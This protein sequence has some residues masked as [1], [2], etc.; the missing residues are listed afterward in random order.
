[1]AETHHIVG[2]PRGEP[3]PAGR[4]GARIRVPLSGT[5]SAD[6]S[7]V[8]TAR[9]TAALTGHQAVGHLQLGGVIHGADI[10]LDGVEAA[11]ASRLGDAIGGA[12][13]AA[14]R[15]GAQAVAGEQAQ[16]MSREQA[17]DIA[18]QIKLQ[19]EFESGRKASSEHFP[20]R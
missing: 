6:W 19:Y 18:R 3:L 11:E 9:L 4:V 13:T 12:V 10:V 7:R 5:P 2:P 20:G 16:N 15:G 14:N 1:M 8:L 17:N